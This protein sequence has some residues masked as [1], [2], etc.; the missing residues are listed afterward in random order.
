MDGATELLQSLSDAGFAMAIGSSG[1]PENVQCVLDELP[2]GNFI[3]ASVNGQ[4]VSK[5]KPDPEVFLKAAKKLGISPKRCA[6][7]EDAPAGIQAARAAGSVAIAL[8]GTASRAK[9]A[10]QAHLVVDSLREL[11]P[12][13]IAEWIGHNA[14]S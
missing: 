8:T 5:G 10:E 3:A 6:V 11:T 1:P 12:E 13:C 4:D 7:V 14:A 2:G 9:L